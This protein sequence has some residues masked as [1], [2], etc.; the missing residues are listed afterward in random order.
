MQRERLNAEQLLD[1]KIRTAG[2]QMIPVATFTTLKTQAAPQSLDHFQQLNAATISAVTV[3][4]VTLGQA[5][6]AL[7][8]LA[9][10]GLP[11]GYSVDYAGQ[12]R[13]Y[14][15]ES[16]ALVVTFFFALIIIFLALA[17]QF[18]SFR[19]PLIVMVSVPL[20]DLRGDDL[21]QPRGRRRQPEYLYPGGAGDPDRPDLA[22]TA[23]SSFSSPMTCS[24]KGKASARP[25]SWPP[26]SA[27]GRSL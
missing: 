19:D 6:D 10:E 9:Q 11:Q 18:E 17:A 3:P 5:L 15:Q 16:T 2:G 1:Y 14:M 7:K 4:G 23:S 20:V 26:A 8:K 13:Q 21:H 25:S 12:S 24:G 27:C 22:N